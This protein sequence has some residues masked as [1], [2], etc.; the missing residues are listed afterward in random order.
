MAFIPKQNGRRKFRQGMF[1]PNN[2]HKYKGD[3]NNIRYMSSWELKLQEFLDNNPN[4]LEWSSETIRIPY[5]K[6]TDGRVHHY[7]PDFYV[8]VKVKDGNIREEIIEVKPFKETRESKARKPSTLLYEQVTYQVNLAKWAA[9]EAWCKQRGF[10][11]RILTERSLFK[12]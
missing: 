3:V 4:V 6:P 1:K 11:F 8:K 9:A 7:L 12:K 10:H 2:P 5:I